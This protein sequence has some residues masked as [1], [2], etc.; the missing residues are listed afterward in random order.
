MIMLLLLLLLYGS[1]LSVRGDPYPNYYVY[2]YCTLNY[3]CLV[4][5]ILTSAGWLHVACLIFVG[6]LLCVVPSV[7]NDRTKS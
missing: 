3:G 5:M 6:S 4:G 1:P 7:I 2:V